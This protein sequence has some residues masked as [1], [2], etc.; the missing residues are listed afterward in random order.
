MAPSDNLVRAYIGPDAAQIRSADTDGPDLL[1]GHFAVFDEWTTINSRYEGHFLER[2]VPG[3]FTR[4]LAERADRIKVLYDHGRDPSVGNKPLGTPTRLAE[5]ERG[6]AYEVALFDASYVNDLKPAMRARALGSSFRFSVADGGDTWDQPM[7]AT[8]WNPDRLPERTITDA[9]VFEFGPV[10][11]PAYA[12]ATA[13]MRS[14]TDDVFSDLRYVAS[15]TDRLGLA[16]VEKMLAG[17]PG[18]ARDL[19][20]QSERD[21][22]AEDLLP[23]STRRAWIAARMYR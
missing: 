12:G 20:P 11:F 7:R 5:D 6:V 16:V 23:L 14:V 13:G 9:D 10:T 2:L 1:H 21:D 15:L 8:E 19:E 17:M 18:D 3:A 22:I 4:T